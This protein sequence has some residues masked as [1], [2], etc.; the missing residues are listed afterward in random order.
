MECT[1]DK[2]TFAS[3]V[4]PFLSHV[5]STNTRQA[6]QTD[7]GHSRA[8]SFVSQWKK[9]IHYYVHNK[10]MPAGIWVAQALH[11]VTRRVGIKVE[12][13]SRKRKMIVSVRRLARS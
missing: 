13:Y 3:I 9:S 5:I 4:F 7:G 1:L 11:R 8:T 2:L 12:A 6:H 10:D